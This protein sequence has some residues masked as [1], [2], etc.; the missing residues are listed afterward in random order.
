MESA[1][2]VL[3]SNKPEDIVNIVQILKVANYIKKRGG[4]NKETRPGRPSPSVPTFEVTDSA[5]G[6][7]FRTI[8][9][10]EKETPNTTWQQSLAVT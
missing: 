4:Q 3:L 10:S 9:L 8:K 1:P 6:F 5:S 2:L 7:F